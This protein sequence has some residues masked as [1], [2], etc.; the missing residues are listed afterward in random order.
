MP[1]GKAMKKT[2]FILVALTL[3]CAAFIIPTA[4]YTDGE[5][6]YSEDFT[7]PTLDY[8]DKNDNYE[9]VVVNG[10]LELTCFSGSKREQGMLASAR[11]VALKPKKED[12]RGNMVVFSAATDDETAFPYEQKGHGLFT[13]YLLKKLQ[14]S[15]GNASLGE[16]STYIT[17]NVKRQS[18][19]INRKV[20]TPTATP[21]TSL[22]NEWTDMRLK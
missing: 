19:V 22:V 5:V 13:Y 10:K 7:N 3:L 21:S 16:L 18:V 12:P 8:T 4:A 14:E 17:E 2:I 15:K 20:H 11:G 6:I 9:A 1:G